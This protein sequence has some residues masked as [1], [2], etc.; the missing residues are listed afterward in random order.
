MS[1]EKRAEQLAF[2][3]TEPSYDVAFV[4][5]N[6]TVYFAHFLSAAKAPSSA[7]VKLLQGVFDRF[8]D[9]SFFI[10]RQRVFT[11]AP[12]T[13]M[14]RGMIKVV[15]KR[16]TGDVR[17]FD[18]QM[19]PQANFLSVTDKEL[20]LAPVQHL[21]VENSVDITAMQ[22]KLSIQANQSHQQHL[23]NVRTLSRTVPRGE[24]LHDYD[25]DIGA[26]LISSDGKLLSYGVN[27]NSKNKT[28]HAE[29]NLLQRLSQQQNIRIPK[30]AVLYSTHKPCKMCAGMIFHWC[31]DPE[32]LRV[33]YSIEESG[34]MSRQTIL[35][36][37]AINKR[38]QVD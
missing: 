27:S 36:E 14:C 1:L 24:I 28:L 19:S 2:L 13:E 35:D 38:L 23:R 6:G 16:A 37:L 32:N 8:I 7:V 4:E 30:G 25:R 9:H 33:Y 18:H 26:Y 29:V 20:T 12:L 10:L 11:T 15:A 31:E 21:N 17:P 34:L 3:L 5:H 22:V